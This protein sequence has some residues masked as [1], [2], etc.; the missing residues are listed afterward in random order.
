MF[1]LNTYPVMNTGDIQCICFVLHGQS[2]D[3]SS[4]DKTGDERCEGFYVHIDC[5]GL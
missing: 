5:V 1:K 2:V 3:F 4:F